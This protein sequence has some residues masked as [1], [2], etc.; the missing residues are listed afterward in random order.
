M[1]ARFEAVFLAANRALIFWIMVVMVAMVFANVVGRYVFGISLNWVEEV[2]RYLMVALAF[3]SAGLAMREGRI[4]AL[5]LLQTLCP[6]RVCRAMRIAVAAIVL[7][8]ILVLLVTGL[9]FALFA[10]QNETPVLNIPQGI[11]YLVVPAGA[12]VFIVHFVLIFR[13]YVARTVE[14]TSTIESQD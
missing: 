7:G 6:L 12:L 2:S 11:P 10:W 1:V 3:F 9:Q 13:P 5:E 4:V 14:V 8:F